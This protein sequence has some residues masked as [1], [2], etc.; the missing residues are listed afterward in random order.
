MHCS[1]GGSCGALLCCRQDIK[2][3]AI[4]IFA[5]RQGGFFGVDGSLAARL[6]H[7]DCAFQTKTNSRS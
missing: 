4:S 1:P 5:I 2:A 6:I 3:H 7:K